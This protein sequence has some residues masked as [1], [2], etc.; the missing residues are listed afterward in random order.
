[1]KSMAGRVGIF[2]GSRGYAGAA[3]M[4]ASG[5][6]HAGAGLITLFTDATGYETVAAKAPPEIMVRPVDSVSE[7]RNFETAG[8]FA[9]GPGLGRAYDA[10]LRDWIREERRPMILDAA[11]LNAVAP[12]PWT[13]Q[14][15]HGPRL[16]TPHPGEFIRIFPNAP[17]NRLEAAHAFIAQYP[18]VTL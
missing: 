3:V 18:R 8:V 1:H 16:I 12:E 17:S 2:A 14:H 15:V 11:A 6:L 10:E 4:T 13:L 5:A 9:V 7:V